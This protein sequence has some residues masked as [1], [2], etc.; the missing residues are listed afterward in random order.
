MFAICATARVGRPSQPA[1]ICCLSQR[2]RLVAITAGALRNVNPRSFA[3]A[4][5]DLA[6]ATVPASGFSV[7]RC[8]PADRAATLTS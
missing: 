6:S 3:R 8:L 5:T 2:K 4:E 7:K 1:S